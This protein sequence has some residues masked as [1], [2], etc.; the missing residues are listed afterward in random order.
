MTLKL[1]MC[2]VERV[3]PKGY[4]IVLVPGEVARENL[5]RID[6]EVRRKLELARG[7][8]DSF[9]HTLAVKL[10][11]GCDMMLSGERVGR[12]EDLFPGRQLEAVEIA[13]AGAFSDGYVW[14]GVKLVLGSAAVQ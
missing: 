5:L 6:T 1:G 10:K 13:L 11:R 2:R 7:P 14:A 9:H 3:T 4:L 12:R 8:W